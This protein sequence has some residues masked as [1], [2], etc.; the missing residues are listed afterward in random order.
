[1]YARE[2]MRDAPELDVLLDRCMSNDYGVDK[3]DFFFM[4]RISE[5][6]Q[7]RVPDF[8]PADG[9]WYGAS[10][11]VAGG[12]LQATFRKAGYGNDALIANRQIIEA[13]VQ[14]EIET[15]RGNPTKRGDNFSYD[16]KKG[17]YH[18]LAAAVKDKE[19]S[20]LDLERNIRED[21]IRQVHDFYGLCENGSDEVFIHINFDTPL[22]ADT[23]LFLPFKE[24]RKFTNQELA[25]L[26][27]AYL[28]NLYPFTAHLMHWYFLKK[29]LE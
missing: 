11:I 10:V 3:F 21:F 14:H 24:R 9:H 16:E 7:S 15:I 19:P 27:S 18:K 13:N 22:F 2:L 8:N 4:Q 6:D 26:S 20:A 12:L 25:R 17:L 29:F 5:R 1:M 28:H 23:K